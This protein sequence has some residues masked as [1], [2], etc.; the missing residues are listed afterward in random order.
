MNTMRS[1]WPPARPPTVSTLGLVVVPDVDRLPVTVPAA[2]AAAAAAAAALRLPL[3]LPLPLLALLLPL[4]AE[5]L[6]SRRG[7]LASQRVATALLGVSAPTVTADSA[8]RSSHVAA[9]ERGPWR[10]RRMM[11]VQ[12]FVTRVDKSKSAGVHDFSVEMSRTVR[13]LREDC[14]LLLLYL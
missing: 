5:T 14:Y 6:S 9:V 11:A 2:T 3:P 8:C 1:R 7:V 4:K 12:L 13:V 10:C